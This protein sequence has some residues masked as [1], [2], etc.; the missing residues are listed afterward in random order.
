MSTWLKMVILMALCV[1]A[2][3]CYSALVVASDAD[4]RAEEMRKKLE[5]RNDETD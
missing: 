3:L 1:M 5:A 4:D 2:V